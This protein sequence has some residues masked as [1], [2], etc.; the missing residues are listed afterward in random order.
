MK[1]LLLFVVLLFGLTLGL[2]GCGSSSSGGKT[3]RVGMDAA[4]PPLGS[5]T[6]KQS[7][8]KVLM[9]TLSKPLQRKKAWRRIS[10]M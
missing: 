2:S 7:P 8:M 9:W 4:Y 10:T 1:K 6:W 5:R 3:L